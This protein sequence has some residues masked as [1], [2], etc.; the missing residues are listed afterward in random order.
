VLVRQRKKPPDVHA[1][2]RE[3]GAGWDHEAKVEEF[4]RLA[5]QAPRTPGNRHALLA[6]RD[7]HPR[8]PS[9]ALRILSLLGR[10]PLFRRYCYRLVG[11]HLARHP[12]RALVEG[13]IAGLAA[14]LDLSQTMERT[15]FLR[16]VVDARGVGLMRWV[17]RGVERP[18][19]FDVGANIGNHSAAIRDIAGHV[20]AFEPNPALHERLQHLIARNRIANIS[21][22]GLAL[23]DRTS[24]ALLSVPPGQN[25]RGALKSELNGGTGIA[26]ETMT[27]D[28]VVASHGI[29]R[30]DLV[31]FD[32]EGHEPAV[33][34]GLAE[35]LRRLRPVVVFER[36]ATGEAH[37]GQAFS[38]LL[39]GYRLFGTRKRRAM[40]GRP[41]GYRLEPFDDAA[42]YAMVLAVPKERSDA[43]LGPYWSKRLRRSG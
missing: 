20:Y 26:V 16:G 2:G 15:I 32:V 33:L 5:A 40:I 36:Y 38:R 27:G 17:V 4:R 31:K 9:A 1:D 42:P 22:L 28:A 29:D 6:M 7:P 12:N 41:P 19:V 11:R 3:L 39:P 21:A 24:T 34:A 30:L 10:V 37:S 14:Q 13:R 43:V 18:V 23:S 25:E 35:T 8:T